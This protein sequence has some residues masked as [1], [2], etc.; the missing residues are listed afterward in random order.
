MKLILA[1][2][3][4]CSLVG[5]SAIASADPV[6]PGTLEIPV[7]KIVGRVVRPLAAVEVN[8]VAPVLRLKEPEGSFVARAERAVQREPF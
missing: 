6:E 1:A 8:R 7:V 3:F 2:S 5:V 4:A